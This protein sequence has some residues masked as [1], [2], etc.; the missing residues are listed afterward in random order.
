MRG[1]TGKESVQSGGTHV[2]GGQVLEGKFG[3][4][5]VDAE[6][7]STA[8]RFYSFSFPHHTAFHIGWMSFFTSFVSTFAAAALIPVIRDDLDLDVVDIGNGGVAAVTGTIFCRISMGIICDTFGPRFGIASILLITAPAVFGMA[9]VT[10]ALGFILCRFF[11]GFGLATFVAGQFWASVM[12]TPKIVGV[13]NATTAGW[14]NLGGGVTQ[15]MIP[16]VYVGCL[17][18]SESNTAWRQAFFLPGCMHIA[19]GVSALLFTQDLPDGSYA[20][21]QKKGKMAQPNARRTLVQAL[22]NYRMWC[23]VISY[24]F[25]FGVELTMNNI[26][27]QYYY[28]Q[29]D[30]PLTVA[31]GLGALFGLMNLFARS[32]GGFLSDQA[33]Q[34]YGMRGRLWALWIV[35]T[36]EGA[37]CVLMGWSKDSLAATVLLM[38][39]FS[40]FVQ[41]SEGASYGVVP[42][43]SKRS[44]GMV[45]GFVGAGGNAGSAITMLIFFKSAKYPTYVGIQLMG[46]MI[47]CMTLTVHFVHFPM[48]GSMWFPADGKTTEE[49]YYTDVYTEEEKAIGMADAAYKFSANARMTEA[50]KN[51]ASA[52][53]SDA[54]AATSV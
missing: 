47:M 16:A 50:P 26:V 1:V 48:W 12:F 31:G 43:V 3:G 8:F 22:S 54:A 5:P 15:F 17:A 21:L 9:N 39:L 37:L 29:F 11:I 42:F 25:C 46:V 18:Y 2:P 7:K 44:L 32:L 34:R 27:V 30:L 49:D 36:L 20:D 23:L 33:A 28:D 19:V 51:T 40:L 24:A 13:A 53:E 4:I 10:S 38:V 45:S 6:N 35:Q 41:A 52:A 14:G